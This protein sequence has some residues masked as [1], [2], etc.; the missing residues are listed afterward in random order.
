MPSPKQINILPQGGDSNPGLRH[1]LDDGF[2]LIEMMVS[3]LIILLLMSA[4]FPFIM[5]SQKR[6]QGNQVVSESNQSARA[7][8]EVMTQEIGQAGYNPQ[9][10]PNKTSTT[11]VVLNGTPYWCITLSNITG[12]NPGD[13]VSLDTGANNELPEVFETSTSYAVLPD[14]NGCQPSPPISP[15][16]QVKPLMNH[17]APYIVS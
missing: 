17:T 2:S 4:I 12:I 1:S 16:I 15:W 5:Q 9:F 11:S 8:L 7:A 13:W 14:A 6:F 10:Y 3:V